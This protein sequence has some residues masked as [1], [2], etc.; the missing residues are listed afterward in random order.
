ML[1][2]VV[3]LGGGILGLI[4][5][6]IFSTH[7]FAS[8]DSTAVTWEA[9]T[10]PAGVYTITSTARNETSGE[11]FTTTSLNVRLPQAM[12]VQ[13]FANL[14]AGSFTVSAVARNLQGKSFQSDAQTIAT[15]GYSAF[16]TTRRRPP[17]APPTSFARSRNAP[18]PTPTPTPSPGDRR[19]TT[20][21]APSDAGG[22]VLLGSL[23]WRRFDLVD[24]DEDG[25]ADLLRVELATGEIR[26]WR[27]VR[28]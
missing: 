26:M 3:L 2:A 1:R 20:D 23:D 24:T 22:S 17:A 14:P 16:V 18:A 9:S 10:C 19:V 12:F 4:A 21:A 6:S 28:R 7:V 11:S 15:A 25:L 27:I 8:L 5:G 13:Q